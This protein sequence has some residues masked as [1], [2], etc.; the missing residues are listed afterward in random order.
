VKIKLTSNCALRIQGRGDFSVPESVETIGELLRYLGRRIDFVF[1]DKD[2][3]MLRPDVEILLN[4]K[5]I[6]FFP[7]GLKTKIEE[8]DSVDITLTPLGGG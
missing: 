6:L 5:E 3:D 2:G 4:G 1:V 7:R 8:G